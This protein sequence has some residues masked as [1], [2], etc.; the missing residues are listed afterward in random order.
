MNVRPNACEIRGI[1]AATERLIAF[2]WRGHRLL[3]TLVGEVLPEQVR[4]LRFRRGRLTGRCRFGCRAVL[5]PGPVSASCRESGRHAIV[6]SAAFNLAS[7][8][9]D[10][11]VFNTRGL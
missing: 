4:K 9:F 7:S 8:S 3:L 1:Q 6:L 11:D 10:S 5:R 2:L